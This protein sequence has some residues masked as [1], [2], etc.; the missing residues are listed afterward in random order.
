MFQ[1]SIQG[2][3]DGFVQ[4]SQATVDL[5]VA[6]TSLFDVGETLRVGADVWDRLTR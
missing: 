3:M 5:S 6:A 4:L 1:R 2:Y